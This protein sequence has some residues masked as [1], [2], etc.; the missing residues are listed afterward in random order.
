[1]AAALASPK[2]GPELLGVHGIPGGSSQTGTA[3]GVEAAQAA[4]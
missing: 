2:Q 3:N 1:M 4:A